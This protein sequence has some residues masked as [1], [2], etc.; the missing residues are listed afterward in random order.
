MDETELDFDFDAEAETSGTLAA[1]QAKL[2]KNWQL[3]WKTSV[4]LTLICQPGYKR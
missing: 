2:Q 4:K 1:A 3:C